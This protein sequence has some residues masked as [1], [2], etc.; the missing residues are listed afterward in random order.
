MLLWIVL[1]GVPILLGIY[2]QMRV[3]SVYNKNVQIPSRGHIT[4]AEAASA[5]IRSAGITDVEIVEV[6]GQLTDHYDPMNKR[7]ALSTD[8]YRGTSLAALG[9]AA[10]EAGHAIQHKVGYSMMT[11]R[12]NLVPAVKFAAPVAYFLTGFGLYLIGSGG[13]ILLQIGIAALAI[14]TLFQL[15]T[16]PVEFDAS[17]RAKAQLVSLGIIDRDE[18]PGV[19]E[20]LDAAALTYVA[21]FVSSL[22]YLL[23]LLTAFGGNRSSDE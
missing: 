22:G 19:R 12:Q 14:M 18:M 16:L 23:Y 20:T 21:A 11:L 3:S 4:G 7:L 15:V 13:G 9:V 10:H 2:A 1:I 8:N 17:N 5:V 6:P